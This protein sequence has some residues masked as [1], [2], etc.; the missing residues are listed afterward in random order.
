MRWLLVLVLVTGL[1]P[2]LAEVAEAVVHVAFDGH[3]P[4]T[5]TDPCGSERGGEHGCGTTLHHCTCCPSQ[6]LGAAREAVRL[7]RQDLPLEPLAA[8]QT[9][10]SGGEPTRLFRPP[11]G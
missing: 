2:D 5:A 3:V 9:L 1:A 10:E 8:V 11:I 4:H 7:T 6:A